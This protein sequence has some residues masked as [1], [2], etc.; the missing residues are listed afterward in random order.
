M[1]K[2]GDQIWNIENLIKTI[3]MLIMKRKI[4][5]KIVEKLYQK[6]YKLRIENMFKNIQNLVYK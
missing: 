5:D 3:K 4:S 6:I 1:D 2:T